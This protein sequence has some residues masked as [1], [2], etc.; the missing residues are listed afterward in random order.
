MDGDNRASEDS[1]T[2]EGGRSARFVVLRHAVH[3]D[4]HFD[5]MIQMG[6]ALATWK[7]RDRPE[8]TTPVPVTCHR[9]ADHRLVY[10]DYEGPISKDRGH[11]SRHDAGDCIFD[12]AGET[13]LNVHFRGQLLQGS[14]RLEQPSPQGWFLRRLGG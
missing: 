12:W 6:E 7:F 9:I 11:V 8:R 13:A 10:L 4:T 5:L 14:F 1:T 3:D 2:T